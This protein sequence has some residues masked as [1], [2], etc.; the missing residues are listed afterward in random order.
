MKQDNRGVSLV[1]ILIATAILVI[2][3]VPLFKSMILTVQTNAKSRVLLA[4]TSAGEAVLE[5]LKSEGMEAF[6]QDKDSRPISDVSYIEKDGKKV[7]Y[8]FTYPEYEADGKKFEIKVE[9]CPYQNTEDA[10]ADYNTKEVADLKRIDLSKDAV[11]VQDEKIIEEDFV[12]AVAEGKVQAEEKDTILK[13]LDI[14]WN[15]VLAADKNQQNIWQNVSYYYN[16]L[17]LG[18]HPMLLYDSRQAGGTLENLYICFEPNAKNTIT[19]QNK[20]DYPLTLFLVKQGEQAA[21]VDVQ[22]IGSKEKEHFG[23]EQDP[24]FTQGIRVR[25][26][27]TDADTPSFSYQG[28]GGKA[29]LNQTQLEKYFGLSGLDGKRVH[30][31]LYDVTVRVNK[32]QKEITTLTGTVTR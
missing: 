25:A 10:D 18:E 23:E 9:V 5:D 20:D 14:R 11:Y 16:G 15:Y 12:K 24:D 8:S 1:E 29:S 22:L 6:I 4:A 27:F 13:N 17:L 2:C 3:V 30:T 21:K 31:R 32:N 7:G 26:N 19:I 28:T